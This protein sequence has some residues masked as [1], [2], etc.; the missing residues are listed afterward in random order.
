[1][2][3]ELRN[4]AESAE[5]FRIDPESLRRMYREGRAPGYKCGNRLRFDLDELREAFRSRPAQRETRSA[6]SPNFA[7]LDEP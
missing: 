2:P 6:V 5:Y 7:A 3:G 4:T 1:M